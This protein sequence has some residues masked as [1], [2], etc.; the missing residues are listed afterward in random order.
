M[1]DVITGIDSTLKDDQSES[2]PAMKAARLMLPMLL[3]RTKSVDDAALGS[4]CLRYAEMLHWIA[5][6]KDM[7]HGDPGPVLDGHSIEEIGAGS[8]SGRDGNGEVDSGGVSD[9]DVRPGEPASQNPGNGLEAEVQGAVRDDGAVSRPAV[10]LVGP[11]REARKLNVVNIRG[12][13]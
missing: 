6:G 2:A 10:P 11:R 3:R 5:T 12:S 4:F 8:T 13:A 9:T 1:G 7:S